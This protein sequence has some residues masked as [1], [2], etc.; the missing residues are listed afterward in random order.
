ML[1]SVKISSSESPARALGSHEAPGDGG[2]WAGSVLMGISFH[3]PHLAPA[4]APL[5]PP[6]PRDMCLMVHVGDAQCPPFK[7][8]QAAS[9][10]PPHS[11]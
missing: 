7:E 11:L 1:W 5:V 8:L 9:P 6:A 10:A 4:N 3:G 2:N